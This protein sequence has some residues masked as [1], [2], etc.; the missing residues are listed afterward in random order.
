MK[1]INT[2][3]ALALMASMPLMA[4]T[5]NVTGNSTI[6]G[7]FLG[8]PNASDLDIR[9]GNLSRIIVSSTGS[10]T[11]PGMSGAN[12]RL[13]QASSTGLLS[14]FAMSTAANVLCGDGIWRPLNTISSAQWISSGTH[15][16]SGNTGSVGVGVN[17][18]SLANPSKLNLQ[19]D[20]DN[21]TFYSYSN[22]TAD[23]KINSIIR[24]NR[25]G[26]I[27]LAIQSDKLVTDL[28]TGITHRWMPL[29]IFGNGKMQFSTISAVGAGTGKGNP[30]EIFCVKGVVNPI[31]NYNYNGG[32]GAP[33]NFSLFEDGG[34]TINSNNYQLPLGY[35]FAVGGKV[36][37]EELVVKL[38]ATWPDY[39]FSNTYKLK[40]L[41]ELETYIAENKHLPN[42]P[43]AQEVA[44]KGFET[45]DIIKRQMEK[46]E[47]LSLYLIQ[48]NKLIAAQ[49]KQLDMQSQQAKVQE[50]RLELLEVKMK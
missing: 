14:P 5:W 6:K 10:I 33:S 9:T 1:K 29:T 26:A 4:Q 2:L 45:G 38:R 23:L 50:K 48:Q 19:G 46:I 47:E 32:I 11:M 17:P 13:L 36:I 37:C 28:P 49:Q 42:I 40:D 7:Q 41:N 25:D 43:S 20:V 30:I 18:A 22:H 35:Y 8:T 15:L 27:A 24:T 16:Y 3:F 34:V 31:S 12:N 21:T 44:D 39:V